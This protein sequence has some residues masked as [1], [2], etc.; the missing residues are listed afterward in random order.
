MVWI[1]F[2]RILDSQQFHVPH[3]TRRSWTCEHCSEELHAAISTFGRGGTRHAAEQHA[4]YHAGL[5]AERLECPGCGDISSAGTRQDVRERDESKR[6]TRRLWVGSTL[7]ALLVLVVLAHPVIRELRYSWT[8][9]TMALSLACMLASAVSAYFIYPREGTTPRFAAVQFYRAVHGAKSEDARAPDEGVY[10]QGEPVRAWQGA[11]VRL[12]PARGSTWG[13]SGAVLLAL[14]SLLGAVFSL[15]AY[16]GQFVPLVF[17]SRDLAVGTQVKLQVPGQ[18][19][20]GVMVTGT[21]NEAFYASVDVRRSEAHEV[22]VTTSGAVF[23][24]TFELPPSNTGWLVAPALA[25]GVTC[26]VQ[27]SVGYGADATHDVQVLTPA[28]KGE[29]DVFLLPAK[30]DYFFQE[31]PASVVN[32]TKE[33]GLR[34][35]FLRVL[36]CS[37][38]QAPLTP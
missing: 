12:L 23:D 17:A 29:P 31:P 25:D 9:L 34:K 37:D 35:T 8:L 5:A 24:K 26:I 4:Y 10:R 15:R 21:V 28:R 20:E 1:I 3:E 30:V 33:P 11:S 6:R 13:F 19:P 14:A 36:A 32:D 16:Y 38:A 18:A 7:S 27:E 22:R 2:P